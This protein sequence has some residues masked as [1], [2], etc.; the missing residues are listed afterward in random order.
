MKLQPYIHKAQYYETDQMGIIHHSN[1]IRWF[2]EARVYFMD[3]MGFGYRELEKINIVSPVLSAYCEYKSMVRFGDSVYILPSI[4][5]FTGSK[6][7]ISYRI[8]DV[9]TGALRAAGETHHGFLSSDG[10]PVS[11]KRENRY[12]FDLFSKIVNQELWELP[13]R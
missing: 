12:V 1:Y 7:T 8:L 9:E 2:E 10:R 11:V 6:M 4:I 5:R 3:E 13:D